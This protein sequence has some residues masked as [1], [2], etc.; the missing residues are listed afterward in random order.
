MSKIHSGERISYLEKIG[1]TAIIISEL[2][3]LIGGVL[4][5]LKIALRIGD[6]M[7]SGEFSNWLATA[8]IPWWVHPL[9][10]ATKL[11]TFLG[12]ILT[13]VI[14]YFMHIERT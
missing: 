8:L 2:P 5:G 12:L 4:I 9:E 7:T 14:I 1:L 11:P 13:L 6:P 3:K 10:I